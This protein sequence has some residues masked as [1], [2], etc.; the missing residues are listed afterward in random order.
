LACY[1]LRAIVVASGDGSSSVVSFN[2]I[3]G[4]VNLNGVV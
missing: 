4:G 2:Q 3:V 1:P